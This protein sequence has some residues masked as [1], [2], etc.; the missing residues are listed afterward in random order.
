MTLLI[1]RAKKIDREKMILNSNYSIQ[2]N[3]SFKYKEVHG[4]PFSSHFTE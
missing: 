2:K 3:G 4:N 1:E